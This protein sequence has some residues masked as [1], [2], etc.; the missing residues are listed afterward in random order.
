MSVYFK[1]LWDLPGGLVIRT[2][3]SDAG[4][5]GSIP[6]REAKTPHTLQPKNQNMN[7]KQHYAKFNKDFLIL[8]KKLTCLKDVLQ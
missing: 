2:S 8:K 5:A 1:D 3:P 6:H 7:Q 4:A